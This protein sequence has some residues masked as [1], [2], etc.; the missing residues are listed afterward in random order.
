MTCEALRLNYVAARWVHADDAAVAAMNI[1][2]QGVQ[3]ASDRHGN[4]VLLFSSEWD[5]DYTQKQNERVTLATTA[6]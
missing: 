5:L 4:P 1:P 3:R 2:L 6:P